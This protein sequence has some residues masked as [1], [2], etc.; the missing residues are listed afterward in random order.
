MSNNPLILSYNKYKQ[1]EEYAPASSPSV[2]SSNSFEKNEL[3]YHSFFLPNQS[4]LTEES[5]INNDII[6]TNTNLNLQ[7][8]VIIIYT[9]QKRIKISI[10][11]I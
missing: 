9:V 7:V 11:K 3:I 2:S 10:K 1:I 5:L 4:A 6:K 8:M